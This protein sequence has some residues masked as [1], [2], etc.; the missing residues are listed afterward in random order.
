[1]RWILRAVES[2]RALHNVLEKYEGKKEQDM[3]MDNSLIW[4]VLSEWKVCL[5]GWFG[6]H[7]LE[8][9]E[10]SMGCM[11]NLSQGLLS[12]ELCFRSII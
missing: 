11:M 12:L 10:D 5:Q 3:S 1:M 4:Y 6:D 2:R 7:V 9:F 8:S